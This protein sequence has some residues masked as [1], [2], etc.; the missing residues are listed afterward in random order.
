MEGLIIVVIILVI[1]VLFAIF[2]LNFWRC[3]S[4]TAISDFDAKEV[5]KFRREK[6]LEEA[7]KKERRFSKSDIEDYRGFGTLRKKN[8]KK[9]EEMYIETNGTVYVELKFPLIAEAP[10]KKWIRTKYM[11]IISNPVLWSLVIFVEVVLVAVFAEEMIDSQ[12]DLYIATVSA[13]SALFSVLIALLFSSGME[14]NKEN[15]RLYQ[16]L[17]GDIKGMAMWISAL[18]DD[19]KKY[20]ITYVDPVKEDYIKTIDARDSVELELAKIRLLLSVLAPVAKHV[21]R[22]APLKGD[23]GANYDYLD[24][25][26]RIKK[27]FKNDWWSR[28]RNRENPIKLFGKD[29][30]WFLRGPEQYVP[31]HSQAWSRLLHCD[32][33]NRDAYE[34]KFSSIGKTRQEPP[35]DAICKDNQIKVYLYRKIKYMS[36]T[37]N[38]DLFEVIMYCLLDQINIL[39]ERG[40]GVLDQQYAKERDLIMKWQHIYGSWGTMYSL[41]TYDQPSTV[42]FTICL[43]LL[44]YTYVLTHY[45]KSSA[46]KAFRSDGSYEPDWNSEGVG[47]AFQVFYV[48]VKSF[49]TVTPF[50]LFWIFSRTIGKVFKKGNTDAYII[51]NDSLDTQEQV[52]K[53]LS[54][55]IDIDKRDI[56]QFNVSL[57][58]QLRQIKLRDSIKAGP[59]IKKKI[60]NRRG[61]LPPSQES[62]ENDTPR[63]TARLRYKNVN[64]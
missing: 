50:A 64:F 16:A 14:K 1:V 12:M 43:S 33:K 15:K 47:E 7:E 4:A 39:Q 9:N 62:K 31:D 49:L 27:V 58:E 2:L 10:L 20:N 54:N 24:D 60:K 57:E 19:K 30:F 28:I 34:F 21:L 45:Y 40:K 35:N 6:K 26:Y 3:W 56:E 46:V 63:P 44:L 53:L 41:S 32:G 37:T 52:S 59:L 22:Q 8:K 55:R 38:M 61:T 18:T 29:I 51:R 13:F 11:E 5:V 23:E 48:I 42:H 17:C 25:K 36:D